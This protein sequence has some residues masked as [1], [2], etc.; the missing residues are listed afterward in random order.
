MRLHPPHIK[1]VAMLPLLLAEAKQRPKYESSSR[2]TD[3]VAN[4]MA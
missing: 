2:K 1:H 3:P 4:G